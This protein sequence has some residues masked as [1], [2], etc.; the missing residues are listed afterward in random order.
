MIRAPFSRLLRA[1]AASFLFVSCALVAAPQMETLGRGVVAIRTSSTQVYIGWRLLG[2]D[3]DAISFNLYRSVGGATATKL[4]ATPLTLTTDYRDTPASSAFA[5]TLAYHVRPVIGGV[6]QPASAASTLPANAPTQAF[7]SIPL[8]IPAGGTTP[9][10]EA[11]T[12]VANDASP[13]DLDGDGEYELVLKWDPSNAKDNSQA[14]YTGNVLLDAYKLDGTRLWRIDL[15][16]NIRAG[17]HYTQFM[18]YDLD[19]DG[20]AELACKTAPGTLDGLG[21]A[22]LMGSDSAA[23]DYR[24]ASGYIL[25]GPEYLTIFN[26][27]NGAQLAT[28]AYLPGRGTVS[29]WGDS[30]GNRVDRFIAG[31]AYLD[32]NLPSLVMCRG[33]YTQTHLVA[34][35]WRGGAL[36]RR[37]TFSAPNNTPYAG[38][39]NHQLSVADVDADGRQEII[40]GAMAV[41]DDGT[42]L[43][44][45]G[46]GHSDALHVSDFL[47]SRPGIEVFTPQ[48]NAA[49]NG[50]VGTSFRDGRT[51]ELIWTTFGNN[52]VGRACMMDIDP[53]YPGAEA[54]ATNNSNIYS[55]YGH[56]IAT[57]ASNMFHN[58]AVW[59]DADAQREMLDGTTVSR[60]NYATSGRSNLLTATGVSSNNGTKSTPAISGDILGD[61]RE[62]VVWRASD[63]SALR[64]Y[65]TTISAID[66]RRTFLADPQ[67]RVA[68]AWQ[69]VAYNQPP[70][71]SFDVAATPA[72]WAG[73]ATGTW[74]A[75]SAL[76][77]R[78]NT[79]LTASTLHT[80]D[81][82]VLRATS[83]LAVSLSG[84]LAP[85]SLIVDSAAE[86]AVSGP[87]S[88]TSAGTFNKAGTGLLR[89]SAAGTFNTTAN[90]FAGRL[91][92]AT[93]SRLTAPRLTVF[94]GGSI[95]GPGNVVGT[96]ELQSGSGLLLGTSG[97]LAVTGGVTATGTVTVG[98]APG[99]TLAPGTYPV[100]SYTGTLS[101]VPTLAWSGPGLSAVFDTS[102]NGLVS[103]TLTASAVVGPDILSW[104]GTGGAAW[105]FAALNWNGQGGI[106][107]FEDGDT[108]RFDDTASLRA[109]TLNTGVAPADITFDTASTWTISGSG[110]ITGTTS[111]VKSGSGSVSLGTPNTYTGGTRLNEGTLVLAHTNGFGSGPVTLA[112]GTLSMGSLTL[113]N[114]NALVIE[115][116]GRVTGG[117]SGG[118]HGI[119]AV[120]GDG[121]LTLEA[122]SVFDL[123]GS[124]ANFLGRVVFT[125]TS[126]FRFFGGSGSSFAS[127]D[128]GSRTL[129]ARSGSS[130]TLGSLEGTATAVLSGSSGGGN[131]AAVIYT[132][133]TN[134]RDTAYA[135]IIANGNA[136]TSFVKSG[137]GR[138]LLSGAH[139]YT[140]NT[141]VSA[142][143]LIVT[144]SLDVSN[145]TVAS[146][147]TFGGASGGSITFASGSR[148]ALA[149]TPDGILGPVVAGTASVSGLVTVVTE[150]LGGVLEPG[151]YD[152]LTFSGP[153][154]GTPQ[155]VWSPPAG[156]SL[157]AS[158]DTTQTGRIQ[159]ILTD[160]RT[161]LQ[162]WTDQQ[163]GPD[164]ADTIA[165]PLADPDGDGVVNLLEYA[166]G[167]DPLTIDTSIAPASALHAQTGALTLDFTRVPDPSLTYEV[168]ATDSL[169][170]PAVWTL[171]WSSTGTA[172]TAGP[173]TVSDTVAA[174]S[175][176]SR[177]LRLK[178][179]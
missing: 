174:T 172:N 156:S 157:V 120:S 149:V 44:T 171:I 3:S 1:F 129:S 144:G 177:F 138:L 111:V 145:V 99:E 63:N 18:V 143:R 80:G 122:T 46:L 116:A 113:P 26:G 65:T 72:F 73:P 139:T 20:R 165:G 110:A 47:P 163:F 58:F 69:N 95:G 126:S 23:A 28:T 64:I 48:E 108:V 96:L 118:T 31:V 16:R 152:L 179:R 25:T 86:V 83:A 55:A 137:A 37:W 164:A 12:Y 17:A 136:S 130:F 101:A 84:A 2:T 124:M 78:G 150:D 93:G 62:E 175:R 5:S 158:F 8:Q 71:P 125:G 29:S 19:G 168:E 100:L 102:V 60:W 24:N 147:A 41:D 35:D 106:T 91:V 131:N 67:Y 109:I 98:A 123:E 13:A 75:A 56:V 170:A 94:P 176:P 51:G 70:H 107:T 173:V 159:I 153:L 128:L 97:A 141:T 148:L 119:K 104:T 81:Q 169:A 90:L 9:S 59:W 11:F 77:S 178:V 68:L 142:G 166:L 36:T 167:G 160:S 27:L 151:T 114:T 53:R 146:G 105:D 15:G 140:G 40:Y 61:W 132:V 92:M 117:S 162:R 127:F 14:G 22:V 57:K 161:A 155:F 66:R 103:V 154:E 34:W 32:G 134:G 89:W 49:S 79:G 30:Y 52:D 135:G 43:H 87:G 74:D 39:G 45:T 21:D 133:G 6:E 76:W 7:L 115:E 54:W 42:G 88:L 112:G 33:Y 50:N 121:V 38:Q 82:P 4:N 85:G 10:G